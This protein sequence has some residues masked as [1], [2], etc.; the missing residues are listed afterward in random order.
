MSENQISFQNI[1]FHFAKA[2]FTEQLLMTQKEKGLLN[3]N[4]KK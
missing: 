2:E 3:I 4:M 1:V